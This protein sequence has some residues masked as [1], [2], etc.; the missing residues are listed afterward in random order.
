MRH[1]LLLAW[2][3]VSPTL[4]VADRWVRYTSGPFEVLTDAGEKA[5]QETMVRFEEFRHALGTIVGEQDLE[6]PQPIRILIFKNPKGWTSPAPVTMGRDRYAIVLAD[7]A[8][9]DSAIYT[10]LTR[11][12]LDANTNRMPAAFEHGLLE[13]FST[14]D[15]R[16][17]HIVIGT[18]PPKPDLDWARIH[19]LAVSPEYFGRL[20][21]LLYNLRKGVADD[22]A[23]RNAFGKTAAEIEDLAKRHFAAGN[24]QTGTVNSLPM[25]PSDFH[26]R[27]ISDTDMRLARADL[28][29]GDQSAT[30]YRSL[31]NEHLKIAE[32]AEGLGLL[33]LRAHRNDEARGYFAEAMEAGTNSAR[34]CIEYARLESDD[35][36]ADKA[37]LRAAGINSKLAEPFA[38]MAQRDSDPQKRLMHWKAAAERDPRNAAY[39]Q[40][41]AECY[42]AE[43]NYA[44]AAKAWRE[45]EQAAIDP[46]Q[47]ARMH[48]ARIDVEGQRLDYEQAERRRKA[49]EEAR[50]LAK[51]KDAARAHVHE[52]EAKY[53]GDSKPVTDAVPWSDI[54]R[55]PGKVIGSLKQV[56]CLGKQARLVIESDDHK[57]LKLLVVDPAKIAISSSKQ[58]QLGCGVQKPRHVTIEYFPKADARLAT[59]GE[60]ATIEFQ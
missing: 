52:L 3:C 44:D 51:L 59:A 14:F 22:S 50:E 32:S 39:W 40:A 48:Q 10:E 54:P 20:H 47:R 46:A 55:A 38:M 25:A 21:I 27:P 34:A 37:L 5:G 24:F 49:E 7:K 17:I 30:E 18:P 42:L 31:L 29:A 56:D 41:L 23:Y 26:E 57:T 9:I 13:F 6:T 1:A 8:P 11:L 33:A 15:V 12:L 53:N 60:V 28:L 43:H 16:G 36:K 58:E 2:I 45:G 19:M 35:E 4:L